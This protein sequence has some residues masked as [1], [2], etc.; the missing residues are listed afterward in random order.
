MY[1]ASQKKWAADVRCSPISCR[2]GPKA[3]RTGLANRCIIATQ[4]FRPLQ[5]PLCLA[6]NHVRPRR[7]MARRTAHTKEAA[8]TIDPEAAGRPCAA[9]CSRTAGLPPIAAVRADARRR[10]KRAILGRS[11]TP[12][13]AR[14]AYLWRCNIEFGCHRL[15]LLRSQ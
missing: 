11:L 12:I 7:Q 15:T 13:G 5:Q 8:R 1:S 10:A 4:Q 3:S 9:G 14:L 2:A 6:R